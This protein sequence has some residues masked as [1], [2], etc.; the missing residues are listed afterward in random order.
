MRILRVLPLQAYS[1]GLSEVILGNAI[2]KHNLP[3]EELVIMT[4]VR[5]L[6]GHLPRRHL[7]ISLGFASC[8]EWF[9]LKPMSTR[10]ART[11]SN[12]V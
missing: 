9:Y 12:S 5:I 4:K 2:K 8:T 1:N 10:L 7:F 11:R 6:I 3:R